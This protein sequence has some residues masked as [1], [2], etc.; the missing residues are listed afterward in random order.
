MSDFLWELP[1]DL[2]TQIAAFVRDRHVSLT[3][4]VSA[5]LSTVPGFD[6]RGWRDFA[7]VAV[8]LFASATESGGL[9]NRRGVLH[10]FCQAAASTG[11]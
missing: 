3:E 5:A 10:D 2:R 1:H 9:D 4:D 11:V 7:S 6:T 8:N